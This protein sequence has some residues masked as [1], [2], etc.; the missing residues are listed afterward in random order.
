MFETNDSSAQDCV[1]ATVFISFLNVRLKMQKDWRIPLRNDDFHLKCGHLL[2]TG[3]LQ[4]TTI[5]IPGTDYR[6]QPESE[7]IDSPQ[8]IV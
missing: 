7:Q 3:I 1:T 4:Q 8:R 5:S 2:L 6:S